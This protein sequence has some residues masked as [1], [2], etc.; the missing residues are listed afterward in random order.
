MQGI[1]MNKL[2]LKFNGVGNATQ[3]STSSSS[4]ITVTGEQVSQ[5]IPGSLSDLP[6][7]L[8]GGLQRT[9]RY[10][11]AAGAFGDIWKCNLMKPSGTVQVAVK[12][13]RAFES[14][15]DV[16][17]R[18]KAKRVRR[19][20]KVWGRLEHDRILPLLGVANDFGQ[21]S[22]IDSSGRACL[23]DF[24]LSTMMEFIGTSYL[25]SHIQG[26]ARWAAAELFQ[27]PE[28]AAAS[29]SIKCDIYSFGSIALQVLTCKVPYHDVKNNLAVIAQV[30]TGK[31][32]EPPVESQIA[33]MHWEFIQQCWLPPARRPSVGDIV[34]FLAYERQGLSD[35]HELSFPKD[36]MLP[37]AHRLSVGEIPDVQEGQLMRNFQTLNGPMS[38]AQFKC[39]WN[40]GQGQ[41]G[42]TERTAKSMLQHISSQHLHEHPRPDSPVQCRWPGCPVQGSLRRDTMLRHIRE[43]HYGTKYRRAHYGE[44]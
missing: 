23:A 33:S 25:T 8:T 44:L 41:C 37:H 17:V 42:V 22:L 27:V 9:S 16:L 12:T 2:D 15:N 21:M 4:D 39:L 35:A 34:A 11:I 32:P 26:H 6:P 43:R 18:K 24:G 7:D 28:E 13:I 38:E 40:D 31:K 30:I 20:L 19:E 10:P 36:Y 1:E 29:P 3:T 5:K 14:D